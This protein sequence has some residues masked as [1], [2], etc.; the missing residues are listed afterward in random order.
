HRRHPRAAKGIRRAQ[1]EIER[2]A[3]LELDE[4]LPV[5]LVAENPEHPEK[6]GPVGDIVANRRQRR[7]EA[8]SSS[9]R[10]PVSGQLRGR[11]ASG[12]VSPA[13]SK[14]SHALSRLLSAILRRRV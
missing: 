5:A 4:D 8:S 3:V 13:A 11:R 10:T 12:G 7:L 6:R 14:H 1:D 9:S 2:A